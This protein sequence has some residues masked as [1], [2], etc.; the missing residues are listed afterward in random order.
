MN[1]NSVWLRGI[2]GTS[3]SDEEYLKN[4]I[5]FN[6]IINEYVNMV[7]ISPLV[8]SSCEYYLRYLLTLH[9]TPTKKAKLNHS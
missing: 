3:D 4:D 7:L 8:H 6:M 1:V 5:Y 9:F 2:L